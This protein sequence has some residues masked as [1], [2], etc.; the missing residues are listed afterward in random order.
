M[1]KQGS[2]LIQTYY[3]PEATEKAQVVQV[4]RNSYLHIS[5]QDRY[6]IDNNG[7]YDTKFQTN[8]N[9][10]FINH[11]K[12]TGMG[13]IKR[14]GVTEISFPYTTP[15]INPNNWTFWLTDISSNGSPDNSYYTNLPE[16]FYNDLSG[17]A[18][19]L[20]TYLNNQ[21]Y[22][23]DG[24]PSNFGNNKWTVTWEPNSYNFEISNSYTDISGDIHLGPNFS[25]YVL[26]PA[27]SR[28]VNRLMNIQSQIIIVTS[29][30]DRAIG[31][32]PDLNYTK[33][34]DFVSSNLSKCENVKDTLTQFNYNDIIYRLYLD[35]EMAV[36]GQ[37][38]T[39]TPQMNVFRQINNPKYFLWNKDEF[40]NQI[41]IKLYDD[42]GKPFYIPQ[43]NWNLP[44]YLTLHMSET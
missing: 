19:I 37:Y 11:Q 26:D 29:I 41:D 40:L 38:F 25:T 9:N 3:Y 1:S 35:N 44:Y 33:Y 28:T 10:I 7:N 16:G 22:D 21:L 13:S 27:E 4:P 2:G 12:S 5:S 31:G 34:I 18:N 24:N 8:P 42:A 20:T 23:N 6:L 15:N 39:A 43:K 17:L 30:A 32:V 36:A 14:V